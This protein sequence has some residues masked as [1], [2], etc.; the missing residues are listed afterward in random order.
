[1]TYAG[2]P[3]SPRGMRR[4]DGGAGGPGQGT[5]GS[6]TAA[7]TASSSLQDEACQ[8]RARV[9]TSMT[10]TGRPAQFRRGLWP[11]WAVGP[12]RSSRPTWPPSCPPSGAS[13]TARDLRSPGPLRSSAAAGLWGQRCRVRAAGGGRAWRHGSAAG[14]DLAREPIEEPNLPVRSVEQPAPAGG[15]HHRRAGFPDRAGTVGHRRP[16]PAVG[17]GDPGEAGRPRPQPEQWR[18]GRGRRRGDA[19][20]AYTA[21]RPPQRARGASPAPL[22]QGAAGPATAGRP[23]VPRRTRTGPP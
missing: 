8:T 22:G 7:A 10:V 1:M 15:A 2:T 14:P 5:R 13:V 11:R 12:S 23:G 18:A 19:T 20:Q 4:P 3:G 9:R 17:Q 6:G 16:R 21:Q